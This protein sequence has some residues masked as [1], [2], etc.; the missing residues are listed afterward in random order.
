LAGD[1]IRIQAGTYQ[2]QVEIQGKNATSTTEADRIVIEADPAAPVGSVVLRGAVTQCTAGHAI[3]LQQSRYVTIRGLTITGAGGQAISLLGGNNEN[4]AIHIERNRIFGN[5][6]AECSGGITIN[7]GNPDTLIINNL[8]YHNGREGLLFLDQD[9]GPHY[10]IENTIYANDWNGVEVARGH[11]VHLV[12]NLIVHN[13]QASG[14]TGGRVGVL[15]ESTATPDPAGIRLRNNLVCGNR[16]GEIAGPALDSTDS[17][18]L[19]PSGTEGS[20]VSA[21]PTCGS[22]TTLFAN[23]DGADQ[24]A[25]NLDDDFTLALSAPAVDQGLDPRPV[26]PAFSAAL[27]EAD[28]LATSRRPTDGDHNQQAAF[29]VGA[30]EV[31]DNTPPVANAGPDQSLHVGETAH[32]TGA[33]SS[34][35]DG[36]PLT[37]QWTLPQ[38]PAASNAQ[39]LGATT[40]TPSLTIDKP[41]EYHAQLLVHDGTVN[42]VP[43]TVVLTTLN[44]SPVANAG[45]D[46]SVHVGDVAHLDGTG[47]TDVD[48]DAL[49]PEWTVVSVPQ[50]STATLSD[51]L[52]FQPTFGID[53]PGSYVLQ[54]I[55]HDATDTSLPDTVTVTT[56]NS[57]P[58][59]NAGLDQHAIVGRVVQLDGSHSSDADHDPLTYQWTFTARPTGSTASLVGELTVTPTFTPDIAGTYLVQLMVND[60]VV[61]SAPATV[62]ITTT[63][64]VR[65]VANAGPDQEVALGVTVHLDGSQSSD[66][67]GDPLTYQWALLGAPEGSTVTLSTSTTV[68][69]SFTP[70]FAGTYVG[71]L[72]VNDSQVDS[73]P[74]TVVVTVTSPDT[75]PPAPANVTKLTVSPVTNGQVT[76]TGAPGSVE[77]GARVRVTNTRTGQSQLIIATTQGS[78]SVQ[79][80]AQFGDECTVVVIDAA[81]NQSAVLSLQVGAPQLVVTAPTNG[82]TVQAGTLLVRGTVESYGMEVGVTVNDV[83]ASVQGANFVAR[84]PVATETTTLVVQ[85]T[86]ARGARRSETQAVTVTATT[87]PVIAL[88]VSSPLGAAPL[89]VTFSLSSADTT[90]TQLQLDA[91]GDGQ[92]E[93]TGTVLDGQSFTYPTPGLYLPTVVLTDPHGQQHTVNALVHV[94]DPFAL[95][96]ALQ[97]KWTS[98]KEALRS[99]DLAQALTVIASRSRSRYAAIFQALVA[100]LPDV[101]AILTPISL[102]EVRGGEALYEMVRTDGTIT[103]SFELRFRLDDDGIWRLAMF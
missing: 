11:S 42:S 12:N 55:V 33:G 101:D 23:V 86:N 85:A 54:L 44:S 98:L 80:G 37:Y 47:S 46:Q 30:V 71:Q 70:D 35:A 103:K 61:D 15:R 3:R 51:P 25:G 90:S 52:S 10:V 50:G 96:A 22:L 92:F 82:A 84:V 38:R 93:W 45:P 75:T 24:I 41:G 17:G 76:V 64:N 13:G 6:S 87:E 14:S 29:D 26:F 83:V 97:A 95:D 4:V 79:M 39:L 16:L 49:T 77:G 9:G 66:A 74:D 32:L 53:Q 21:S 5:G 63:E 65:P 67:D 91:E 69:P 88:E 68:T 40:V 81:G 8:I 1:T 36:D 94:V 2:E 19:T 20:G 48:G 31:Q 100:D 57:A 28:Y 7:R 73:A 59:A 72:I 56:A 102:L 99:G 78:F 89:T 43:D 34:D 58:V 60:G 62:L 27:V 18:N